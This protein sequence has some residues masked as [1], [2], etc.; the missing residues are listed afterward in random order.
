ML[1][2]TPEGFVFTPHDCQRWMLEA[3]FKSTDVQHLH[4]PDWMVVG[5]K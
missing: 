1:L 4:G 3:G 2:V 5:I